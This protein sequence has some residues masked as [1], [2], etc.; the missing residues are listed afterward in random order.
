VS[1]TA[2]CDVY[3]E[4]NT[5]L[6]YRLPAKWV[7]GR[8]GLWRRYVHAVVT[9][10][11]KKY[12]V[13]R[14]SGSL[15]YAQSRL[16]LSMDG[17]VLA[18]ETPR[19]SA[20]RH[21]QAKFGVRIRPEQASFQNV[22]KYHHEARRQEGYAY[23]TKYSNRFVYTYHVALTLDN[24]ILLPEGSHDREILLLKRRALLRA[25]R[26]PAPSMKKQLPYGRKHYAKAVKRAKIYTK[27]H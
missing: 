24:P 10:A 26:H 22:K 14:Q 23:Y 12:V 11:D 27:H 4:H 1:A 15:L 9:T 13:E 7:D 16:H 17:T 20:A 21:M 19:Q 5:A 3:D 2:W 6:G 18:G 25:L 8:K